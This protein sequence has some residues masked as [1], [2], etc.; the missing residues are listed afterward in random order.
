MAKE[1]LA[2]AAQGALLPRGGTRLPA[3]ATAAGERTVLLIHGH[4]SHA[5]AFLALERRLCRAGHRRIAAFQYPMVG[6]LASV[7][8]ALSRF[9]ADH[10]P[11]GRFVVVGHSLGGL[12]ARAWL[13][14]AGGAARTDA[15]VTL[16]TPH[17]GL[18]LAGLARPLPLVG[19]MA[20][21]APF[22]RALAATVDRLAGIR[23]LS[24]AAARDHFVRPIERAQLEGAELVV[25]PDVGHASLLFSGAAHQH[26]LRV[27]GELPSHRGASA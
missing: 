26:I 10:L 25:I 8:A 5:G 3:E 14:H 19:E 27:L 15:F 9:V 1:V 21:E 16:S 2:Y 13:Q 23:C 24:I 17:L 7:T 12:V 20:P 22:M 11:E 18:P 4:G 6:S